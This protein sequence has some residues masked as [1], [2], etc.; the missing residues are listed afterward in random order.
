MLICIGYKAALPENVWVVSWCIFSVDR[1]WSPTDDEPFVSI[2]LEVVG[3]SVQ[4][5]K[6]RVH[7]QLAAS[8]VDQLAELQM[9]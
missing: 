1:V 6:G 9:S 2:F 5:E 7:F 3:G 4:G 8:T